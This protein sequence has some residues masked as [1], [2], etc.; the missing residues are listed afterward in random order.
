[1]RSSIRSKV[2]SCKVIEAEAKAEVESLYIFLTLLLTRE[3]TPE[4]LKGEPLDDFVK[5]V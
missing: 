4:G 2:P 1:M 3:L 5:N